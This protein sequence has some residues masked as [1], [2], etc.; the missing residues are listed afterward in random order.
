M[1]DTECLPMI[2]AMPLQTLPGRRMAETAGRGRR[3]GTWQAMS[4]AAKAL[5]DK[6]VLRTI[7]VII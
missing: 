5:V 1:R 7:E 3:H 2:G 6:I 4:T